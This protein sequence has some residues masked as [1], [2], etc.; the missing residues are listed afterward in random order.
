MNGFMI[1]SEGVLIQLTTV[2]N[3]LVIDRILDTK[4][5]FVFCIKMIPFLNQ[6]ADTSVGSKSMIKNMS[7]EINKLYKI[8]G[9]CGGKCYQIY[10][11]IVGG[12]NLLEVNGSEKGDTVN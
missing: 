5:S 1:E 11:L 9:H 12:P 4:G 6:V 10:H 7:V 2:E 8:Q 3:T